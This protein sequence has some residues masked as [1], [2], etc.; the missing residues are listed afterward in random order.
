MTYSKSCSHSGYTS[1]LVCLQLTPA[2]APEQKGVSSRLPCDWGRFP[3]PHTGSLEATLTSQPV[4]LGP[5]MMPSFDG[6]NRQSSPRRPHSGMVA[7]MEPQAS[8]KHTFIH[9]FIHFLVLGMDSMASRML[10]LSYTPYPESP[11]RNFT[12]LYIREALWLTS[13]TQRLRLPYS[14]GRPGE[15]EEGRVVLPLAIPAVRGRISQHWF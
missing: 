13:T 9:S 7:E 5:G 10:L 12:C 15:G 6:P 11:H 2:P 14:P 4:E 8:P 3:S 1:L